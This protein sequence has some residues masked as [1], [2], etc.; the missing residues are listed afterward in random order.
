MTLRNLILIVGLALFLVWYV[1]AWAYREL[2][3]APRKELG[4]EIAKLSGEIEYG[5]SK[6]AAM[7]QTWNQNQGYYLRS[8]PPAPNDARQYSFWL[9]E[10]L[11]Y[12]GLD[13]CNVGDGAYSMA[14]LGANYRFTVRCAGSLS[15]LSYFL[16]E[17]Y[18]A[19]FFHRMTTMTLVPTE[20]NRERLTFAMTVNVLA[21]DARYNPYPVTNRLPTGY[22]SRLWFQD[23]ALYNVIAE[24]N[25]MQTAK[26]GVDR[27]DYTFFTSIFTSDGEA[28]VWFSVW[29]DDSTIKTK[30]GDSIHSGSFSGRV[31]EILNQDI[32]LDRNGT[33]WLLTLGESLNEAFALPPE[34]GER[35]ETHTTVDE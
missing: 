13:D 1:S 33:R 2:Y 18:Y 28:E 22:I 3:I 29:T 19:P 34:T 9:L 27:A 17:F 12:S 20:G 10:L 23:P 31:V 14:Q 6:L 25:I 32:V 26:G 5:Q 21:L 35:K 4:D 15:Q 8:L 11:Q 24:R 30:L 7:T 16:F